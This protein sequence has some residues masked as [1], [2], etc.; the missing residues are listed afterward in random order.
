MSK[1]NTWRS[2]F[3][4][5][6]LALRERGNHVLINVLH[7]ENAT[8]GATSVYNGGGGL[9]LIIKKTIQ[10]YGIAQLSIVL[11]VEKDASGK[12]HNCF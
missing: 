9:A 8:F 6:L 11:C 5:T 3:Q 10:K 7:E 1:V 12:F 2:G 4:D